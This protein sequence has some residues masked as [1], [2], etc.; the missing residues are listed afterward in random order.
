M[1]KIIHKVDIA[2]LALIL[3]TLSGGLM[4]ELAQ[5]G[6]WITVMIALMTYLKGR[7]VIDY[8]MELEEARPIIRN[9]VTG[10]S[11][12]IPLL[13]VLTYLWTDQLVSFSE[14]ILGN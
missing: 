8:F 11:T 2:W 6:F 10:F 14:L 13:M 12:I 3:L 7:L 9:V 5:P 4:G 1:K